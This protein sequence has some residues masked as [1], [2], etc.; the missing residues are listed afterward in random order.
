MAS[1]FNEKV[2]IDDKEP[3]EPSIL[4]ALSDENLKYV[5]DVEP[6]FHFDEEIP[7]DDDYKWY[8]IIDGEK[9][10]RNNIDPNLTCDG[11]PTIEVQLKHLEELDN[12]RLNKELSEE[13]IL[14]KH[15]KEMLQRIRCIALDAMGKNILIDPR[16][17]SP[18]DKKDFIKRVEELY[19]LSEDEIKI[20]FGNICHD[21]I[22]QSGADYS[23]YVIYDV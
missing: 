23:N 8:E 1:V 15:R 3:K 11:L 14:K 18:R 4:K 17:L 20:M 9:V 19:L 10:K 22:F 6:R 16:K 12:E 7:E 5:D 2:I 13:E 21:T